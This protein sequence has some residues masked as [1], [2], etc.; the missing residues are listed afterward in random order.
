ML[1]QQ[2]GKITYLNKVKRTS[3]TLDKILDHTGTEFIVAAMDNRA[4]EDYPAV[5]LFLSSS[6]SE[7]VDV[8]ISLPLWAFFWEDGTVL[9]E[10]PHTSLTIK[11]AGA[12]VYDF[13]YEA[14]TR[15][16]NYLYKCKFV[17]FTWVYI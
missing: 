5:K 1:D 12:T 8:N 4:L 9:D 3:F 2:A 7:S 17:Y 16:N 10:P 13:G 11:P 14:H 6:Q 15:E